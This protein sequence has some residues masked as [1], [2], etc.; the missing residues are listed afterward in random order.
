MAI[1]LTKLS[2]EE[3][4]LAEG[5]QRSSW[6]ET[7]D[8]YRARD[9][10]ALTERYAPDALSIPAN[11]HMLRGQD[12]IRGWYEK[13]TGNYEMNVQAEVDAVDVVGDLAVVVGVFRVSR[14][15]EEGV[16][17]LDHGGRFLSILK[18]I[19]G[20]WRMWRDMDS[21]SPD[22][23]IFYDRLPRGW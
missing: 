3:R 14:R 6:S 18:K 19:D 7:A 9:L 21:P 13:R 17:G 8:N 11:H 23:D 1:D 4:A 2:D 10:D 16:A 22:A 15:P 5:M 12:E 20:Q